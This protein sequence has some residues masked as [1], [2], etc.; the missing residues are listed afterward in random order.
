MMALVAGSGLRVREGLM[1]VTS[2]GFRFAAPRLALVASL[3][4]LSAF[5]AGA[6]VQAQP[7]PTAGQ[8]PPAFSPAPMV[9][10][11]SPAERAARRALED[12]LAALGRAF[13]GEVG[14]A[15]RDI[16]SDYVA[17]W[18][19]NRLFPQQSVSKFWVALTAFDAVD[20]GRLSLDKSV[21]LR[22][23]DLTLFSQPIAQQVG[24]N[25]YT[26]TIED[27]LR[28]AITRSDNTANDFVLWQAGGPTAV[29]RLIARADIPGV[30]FGPG[31]RLLQSHIAGVTWNQAYSVRVW[32]MIESMRRVDCGDRISPR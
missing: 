3:G 22:R 30:R 23:S 10:T 25:G 14:V 9:A 17:S 19:G 18:N 20:K 27:L 12:R 6:S 4:V 16:N 28:R 29:R 24:A 21:T 13:H 7:A 5:S 8:A 26:T 11:V 2:F 32:S 15:V 1:R 31:E